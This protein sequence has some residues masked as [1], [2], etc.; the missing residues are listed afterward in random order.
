MQL[1]GQNVKR[2]F[3]I[4]RLADGRA[5]VNLGCGARM[6]R[7]WNNIDFSYYARLAGRPRLSGFLRA[8]SV[9]SAARYERLLAADPAIIAWDLRKGVPFPDASF[10]L[11]YHSHVLEHLER[12]NAQ[13]LLAECRRVLKPSGVLR[14]V[15]PDLE[16]LMRDYGRTLPC[17]E[18]AL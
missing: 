17:G 11:V 9:L 3:P 8:C 15:V 13:R 6:H 16:V 2:T 10:D 5:L 14:V 18:G 7:L 4:K 12:N 1:P